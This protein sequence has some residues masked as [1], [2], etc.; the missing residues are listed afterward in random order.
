M[1]ADEQPV[2]DEEIRVVVLKDGDWPGW[3][4]TPEG[5]F[6]L[7]Q[8]IQVRGIIRAFTGGE[9]TEA[10]PT[11]RIPR[12]VCQRATELARERRTRQQLGQLIPEPR[13]PLV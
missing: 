6:A 10:E 3:A 7:D 4:L 11:M 5:E 1:S 8:A 12:D 9:P 2:T 13:S